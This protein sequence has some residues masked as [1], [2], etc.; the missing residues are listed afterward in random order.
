M[1]YS[2]YWH[3]F[4][5]YK[6]TGIQPWYDAPYTGI[7]YKVG[8][9]EGNDPYGRVL[10]NAEL[11]QGIKPTWIETWD[12]ITNLGLKTG[13]KTVKEAKKFEEEVHIK[14]GRK[15]FGINE[16]ISGVREFRVATLERKVLLDSIFNTKEK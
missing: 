7:L 13:F 12:S 3:S 16:T 15:D 10:K 2:V 6:G 5:S 4:N 1:S 8:Y 9:Q 14:L 11:D